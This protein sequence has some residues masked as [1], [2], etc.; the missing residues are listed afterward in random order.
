[1]LLPFFH[2]LV[3]AATEHSR[4]ALLLQIPE[5]SVNVVFIIIDWKPN[6]MN[7]T[8]NKHMERLANTITGVVRNM[9]PTMICMCEAGETKN[10][11]SEEQ[12][13]QVVTQVISAWT[14]AATEDIQLRSMFTTGAPYVTI[15]IHGPIRCSDHRIL[16]NLYSAGGEAR[17]AQTFGCS[18]PC[19]ESIDVVNVH[20][21]LGKIFA[22]R[23][24]D[25]TSESA[26]EQFSKSMTTPI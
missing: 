8:L 11:L 5:T 3:T 6:R 1:M 25:T 19:G 14:A 18:L 13:R 10:P 22:R 26:T 16:E 21:P 24:Q 9:N 23:T 12:M 20:A 17:T 2:H 15:Y 4:Q 7:N